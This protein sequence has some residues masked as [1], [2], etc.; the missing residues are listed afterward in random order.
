MCKRERERE[1]ESCTCVYVTINFVSIIH[2]LTLGDIVLLA[3]LTYK[4]YSGSS[5]TAYLKQE[6]NKTLTSY[7]LPPSN[8]HDTTYTPVLPDYLQLPDEYNLEDLLFYVAVAVG[9]SQASFQLVC[10]FLQVYFY[11]MQRDNPEKWKCQPHR[12]L[13]AS[14]ELH[15]I[16]IGTTN[17]TIGGTLSG[18][19]T[20]WIINGNSTMFYYQIDQYGYLYFLLSFVMVFFWIDGMSF[21][22]HK[23]MHTSLLY[24]HLHKQ[25]HRYD[26][27]CNLMHY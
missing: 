13:T 18:F 26:H 22:Y 16:V 5:L 25:H 21:Y 9:I 6:G 2:F 24:K 14:N 11:K 19:L 7:E 15:E 8:D 3:F 4:T 12:F 27:H 20:C 23:L 17:M 10:G 1:R